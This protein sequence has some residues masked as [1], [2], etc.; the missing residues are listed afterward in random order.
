VVDIV[1]RYMELILL[2]QSELKR[3]LDLDEIQFIKSMVAKEHK[4]GRQETRENLSTL[5]LTHLVKET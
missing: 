4:E 1:S 3:D 2:Y 5:F